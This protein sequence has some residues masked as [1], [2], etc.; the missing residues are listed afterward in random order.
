MPTGFIPYVKLRYRTYP[1]EAPNPQRLVCDSIAACIDAFAELGIDM[2]WALHSRAGKTSFLAYE[3]WVRRDARERFVELPLYTELSDFAAAFHALLQ[4]MVAPFLGDS[5]IHRSFIAVEPGH[6]LAGQPTNY[7]VNMF[8]VL[9]E[10]D[11]TY[12]L[13]RRALEGK[14]DVS[15]PAVGT[16]Y[17]LD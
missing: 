6:D 7:F 4:A 9:D 11:V 17:A 15:T 16:F 3:G 10:S 8:L 12:D 1:G 14:Q 2:N 5:T 13:T